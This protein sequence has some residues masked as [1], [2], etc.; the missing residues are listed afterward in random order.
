LHIRTIA[1]EN[2]VIA[3]LELASDAQRASVRAMAD[4]IEP[5]AGTSPHPLTESATMHMR[6]IVDRAEHFRARR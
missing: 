3:M 5:R 2:T 4:A 6:H 1:L